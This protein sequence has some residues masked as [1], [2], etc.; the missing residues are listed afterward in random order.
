[1][2]HIA[3]RGCA[4]SRRSTGKIAVLLLLIDN[5]DSFTWNLFQLVGAVAQAV[6]PSLKIHVVRN[7][8]ITPR[9]AVE[10]APR[11]L[12]V[13]PGPCTPREAGGSSEI[14]SALAIQGVPTLG[15]CLGHQ[16]IGDRFGAVVERAARIM[17]GK[18][19]EIHHDAKRLFSGIPSP[20]IAARYHSLI[21]RGG[22][23]SNDF[24]VTAWTA[25]REIMGI[26]HKRLPLEGVQFHPESFLTEHGDKV[27]ANFLATR[28][29]ESS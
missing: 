25:H 3:P 21:I 26:R 8:Q 15:V 18:T 4:V 16:C 10:L 23:L 11:F 20:F 28:A 29:V 9:Q 2:D 1:M 14:I 12:V 13:S 19:D 6:A 24:E 7:D 27:I 22:S 17:H 5:Y